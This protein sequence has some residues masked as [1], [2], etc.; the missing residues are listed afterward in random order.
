MHTIAGVI[1]YTAVTSLPYNLTTQRNKQ[2][3]MITKS[4]GINFAIEKTQ[5]N[6]KIFDALSVIYFFQMLLA[7]ISH[8]IYL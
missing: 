3:I 4:N 8:N 2:F 6:W 5:L 1:T 7:I